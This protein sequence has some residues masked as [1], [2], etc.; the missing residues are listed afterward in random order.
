[1]L[2]AG[3]DLCFGQPATTKFG[4]RDTVG[5]GDCNLR[6][7]RAVDFQVFSGNVHPQGIAYLLMQCI[8]GYEA[9]ISF[10]S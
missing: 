9:V 5:G 4:T 8:A 6:I 10:L 2:G 7:R 3:F 1:M